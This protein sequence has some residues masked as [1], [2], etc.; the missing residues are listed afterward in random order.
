MAT[1]RD[2][3]PARCSCGSSLPAS[4]SRRWGFALSPDLAAVWVVVAGASLGAAFPLVLSLPVDYAGDERDAGSKAS[5]ILLVGYVV[6]A[7]G[8]PLIFV[9]DLT[10]DAVP[11]FLLL[12]ACGGA[13]LLATRWLPV[14]GRR[15]L[16]L[17]ITTD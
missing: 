2:S 4:R 15:P 9:R 6:A 17:A 12:A 16:P 11:V 8:P 7:A 3:G 14:S 5:L 13:F 10:L 1:D